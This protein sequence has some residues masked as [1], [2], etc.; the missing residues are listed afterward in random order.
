MPLSRA[1]LGDVT[2]LRVVGSAQ[3]LLLMHSACNSDHSKVAHPSCC[4]QSLPD[5]SV[6]PLGPPE[7]KRGLAA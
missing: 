2:I 7:I 5:F 6:T 3:T 1:I 4:S